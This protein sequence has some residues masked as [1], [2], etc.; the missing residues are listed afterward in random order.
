M[1]GK[2]LVVDAVAKNVK[3]LADVLAEFDTALRRPALRRT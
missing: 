1:T 3:L 2:M